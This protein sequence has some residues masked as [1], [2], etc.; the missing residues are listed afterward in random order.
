V[1]SMKKH[2]AVAAAAA[3]HSNHMKFQK[4]INSYK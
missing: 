2:V 3:A 1:Q 4:S